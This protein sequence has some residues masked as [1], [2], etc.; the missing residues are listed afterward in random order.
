MIQDWNAKGIVISPQDDGTFDVDELAEFVERVRR[1]FPARPV[2]YMQY[3]LRVTAYDNQ[4]AGPY[5]NWRD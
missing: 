4:D 3:A 1:E 5:L 2:V